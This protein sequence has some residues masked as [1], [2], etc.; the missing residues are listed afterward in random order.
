MK[1][2]DKVLQTLE[3]DLI[4]K[5]KNCQ[6]YLSWYMAQCKKVARAQEVLNEYKSKIKNK[7]L[8]D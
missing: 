7:K 4:N 6:E 3:E 5:N 2:I 8:G 1:N